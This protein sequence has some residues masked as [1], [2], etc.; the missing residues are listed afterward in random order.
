MAGFQYIKLSDFFAYTPTATSSASGFPATNL[1]DWTNTRPLVRAWRSSGITAQT[2]TCAFSGAKNGNWMVLL[3]ANFSQVQLAVSSDGTNFV[4]LITGSGTLTTY[5]IW[6]DARDPEGFY[7]LFISQSY[8]G[9]TH[10]RIII[11]AQ[12][13]WTGEAYFKLG[14]LA[15]GNNIAT[16]TQYFHDPLGEEYVDPEYVAEGKD[17]EE[18]NGAGIRYKTLSI[19]NRVPDAQRTEWH[20]LRLLMKAGAR[21]LG[22]HNQDDPSE[23]YIYSRN[24]SVTMTRHGTNQEIDT[25]LRTLS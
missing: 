18:R 15:W 17:W 20:T 12:T 21:V 5:P 6:Q 9:A 14:L 19:H 8:P 22:Y 2:I 25:G 1:S 16:M 13:P 10:G 3:N 7:K 24:R 11:P 4:D 23:V